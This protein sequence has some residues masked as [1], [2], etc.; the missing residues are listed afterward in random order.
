MIGVAALAAACSDQDTTEPHRQSTMSRGTAQA[1]ET[2]PAIVALR[3]ATARYHN[4]DL[5]L[6]D[7]FV[8]LHACES[9]PGEGPVGDVYVNFERL[10]ETIDPDKPEALIYRPLDTGRL[11]LVGVELAVPDVGQEPPQFL[12]ATFQPEPEFGV[13]GLHAWIWLD[14]PDG[15]FA[16]FNPRVS[17]GDE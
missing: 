9:G 7:G 2:D 5:A 4:L 12:G 1:V 3:R 16:E 17:C 11:E 15:L 6:E 8:F 10:D 13:F 14:N